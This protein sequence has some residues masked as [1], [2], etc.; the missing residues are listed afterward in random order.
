MSPSTPQARAGIGLAALLIALGAPGCSPGDRH[1][2]QPSP[3]AIRTD[4]AGASRTSPSRDP[5]GFY[6]LAP[7]N[8]WTYRREVYTEARPLGD[9]A[10][11]RGT[12][13]YDI[14]RT[15]ECE[16]RREG[17]PWWIEQSV[18]HLDGQETPLLWWLPLRQDRD[19]LYEL[20]V[21]P[22]PTFPCGEIR[23]AHASE[24]AA[25]EA[26][27]V[28][29][30]AVAGLNGR[31]VPAR[32]PDDRFLASLERAMAARLA[33]FRRETPGA[34]ARGFGATIL[35][36]LRYPLHVG[37]EW[38]I[39]PETDDHHDPIFSAHVERHETLL[40][41]GERRPAW[42]IRVRSSLFGPNDSVV[43]WYG[44]DGFLGM[45]AEL[46]IVITDDEG[47]VIGTGRGAERERLTSVSAGAP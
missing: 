16:V 37:A 31:K 41:G 11:F 43:L 34:E 9:T 20:E 24:A 35:T 30:A 12:I 6:P 13:G 23:G 1:V 4:G 19:G 25:A 5:G 21:Y 3:G 36:R 46:E 17:T 45:D 40:V 28:V 22:T 26:R 7:G 38:A 14:V 10:A 15:L 39:R 42:R 2:S 33:G 47:T 27:A 18:A 44:R 29:L 8:R 32:I